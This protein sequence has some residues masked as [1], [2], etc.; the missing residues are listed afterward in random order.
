MHHYR[1]WMQAVA[2][3]TQLDIETVALTALIEKA[4][5]LNLGAKISGSG[6]GDCGIAIY[7]PHNY[8]KI[9]KLDME[10][11]KNDIVSLDV[12]VFRHYE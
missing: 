2:S 4:E 6:G 5:I 8:E 12:E 1:K 11:K 9:I 10:W 3:W 7:E